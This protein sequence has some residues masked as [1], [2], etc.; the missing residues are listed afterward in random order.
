M[1]K[2]VLEDVKDFVPEHIFE[3]GQCFRWNKEDDG[4]YTGVAFGKLINVSMTGKTVQLAHTTVEDFDEVWRDYF[5]LDRDYGEIKKSLIGYDDVMVK[6]INSG[7]GIRILRQDTWEVIASFIISANNNI[8]KIKKSVEA[9]AKNYGKKID[10]L[11]GVD[12][13][14]FP[15][16]NEVANLSTD[17][18]AAC[19]L[20]Y[21]S[22]YLIDTAKRLADGGISTLERLKEEGTSEEVFEF[23]LTL[24][25]IGPKVAN[26][27]LLF[28]LGK[29]EAFPIDTWVKKVMKELYGFNEEDTSGMEFFAIEN[30][31]DNAGI[32]QQYL[33][34]Y[35][36]NARPYEASDEEKKYENKVKARLEDKKFEDRGD[37][38][39]G[40]RKFEDRGDRKF[41]DKKFGDR[42]GGFKKD[43]K[44]DGDRK[45]GDRKFEDRGDRKF[46]D[47]KFGD[48]DG[49]F[50]KD[51]KRDGDRK[52]GD[53]K[54]EDR[55]DRKFED[56]KFE[57]RGRDR[58]FEERPVKKYKRG[59]EFKPVPKK[60]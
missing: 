37:R 3:C 36:R 25:G 29:F 18:L 10:R 16:Y 19:G 14:T 11:N 33:F 21:R 28:G 50:K 45:F 51:F 39:F 27:V 30:F 6:A 34:H 40:D 2:I 26:C 1:S 12:Y 52:F 15:S 31:G 57:D 56:K 7:E 38:K 4:S 44:R 9:I 54:F 32:A 58:D 17:D 23:L 53:R 48:R 8:P 60:K 20:G 55:G 41:G 24:P 35:M 46:G 59:P 49:G 5:D 42:D 22:N 13:Y 47:K 43:F